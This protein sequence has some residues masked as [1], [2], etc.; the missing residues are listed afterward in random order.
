M[1]VTG[2]T[3]FKG[4]WL[5]R[6]LH[7]LGAKV[8]G[9]A[10]E[11]EGPTS[12]FDLLALRDRCEHRVGDL[13]DARAVR[14]A[15][16]DARPE[17]VFHLGAQSLVRRSYEA[18]LETWG[19]NVM[20]TAHVLEAL[21]LRRSPCAVVVVTSDK[22]YENLGVDGGC[23]E[24]DPLGGVD[25]YSSSK[26]ATELLVASWRRSFFDPRGIA[27]HGVA[28]A[29]GRAGNVLG[30]GDF[31]IDR[32]VPDAVRSAVSGRAMTVRNP[33][34]VRPWQHVLDP[35]GAY[36]LLAERLL[37]VG[38]DR[39]DAFCDAWNFG[40]RDASARPVRDVVGGLYAA[41]SEAD[42]SRDLQWSERGDPRAPH[43]AA[44][45][46]LNIEKAVTRLGWTPRWDFEAT[47]RATADWYRAWASGASSASL[48]QLCDAQIETWERHGQ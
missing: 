10:L 36:I 22:C 46:R 12:L 19:T 28:L 6:W 25:P 15:M 31:A 26:A 9:F 24:G 44:T 45:L 2:H 17:V 5:V 11:P 16:D 30:G 20:G 41:W 47:L 23:R 38:T 18:P 48:G 33:A 1:F 21:R 29:T 32:V 7:R 4:A 37:G 14:Q 3:G 27:E 43:E 40:P 34:A 39:P 13:R 8:T 35:L 42:P